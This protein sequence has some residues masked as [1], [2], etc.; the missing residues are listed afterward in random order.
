MALIVVAVIIAMSI[1]LGAEQGP[2]ADP[3]STTYVPRP[4][5]YFFFLFELL[6]VIKPPELVPIATIGIPTICMVLLLLLPFYDRGP[7]RRP[8]PPPDRD[9]RRLPDDRRDGLPH[10]PRRHRR[11]ADR[12]RHEGRAPVRGRQGGRRRLGLPRLP[13]AGRE[14]QQ[15]PGPELTH[16]AAAHPAR[17]DH[18]LGRNRPGHHALLPRPAA[19][20]AQRARRLPLLARLSPGSMAG[21]TKPSGTPPSSRGRSTACSTASP[22]ATTLLNSV[23][24]RRPAPP[25]A[26]AGRRPRRARPGRLGPRRLLRHRRPDARAGRRGSPRAATSSAATSPSRCSTSPARRRP[27]AAPRASASSGPTRCSSPT[28]PAA[29]TRSRSASGSATSPTSTAACARW[30]GC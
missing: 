16:I 26:R 17:G 5:W 18:P 11:L 9:H 13:Q 6:R 19:E 1:I 12:D 27:R 21:T 10:L 15:R 23:M 22:A 29:S 24:T 2:K 8:E 20:K 7:E 25:L 3:T 14:R 30:P 28:T 4:E